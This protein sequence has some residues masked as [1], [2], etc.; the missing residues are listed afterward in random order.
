MD[1]TEV[2]AKVRVKRF[3][4]GLYPAMKM[5]RVSTSWGSI[6]D[7]VFAARGTDQL[8]DDYYTSLINIHTVEG[9]AGVAILNPHK[10]KYL[11]V[12][13]TDFFFW[14]SNYLEV[15]SQLSLNQGFEEFLE[16]W[17]AVDSTLGMHDIR[18]I[19]FTVSFE[20]TLSTNANEYLF[21]YIRKSPPVNPTDFKLQYQSRK[22]LDRDPKHKDIPSSETDAFVNQLFQYYSGKPTLPPVLDGA[23]TASG[24]SLDN[25]SGQCIHIDF[26]VSRFYSPLMATASGGPIRKQFDSFHADSD[27]TKEGIIADLKADGISL[28]D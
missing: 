12:Q 25:R 10:E 26:D 3:S 9:N 8:A 28:D 23:M 19:S 11:Q 14:T 2:R 22:W 13:A 24:V 5:L 16:F 1:G 20:V 27:K 6:A 15:D 18:R 4:A 7:R 17:G 21:K